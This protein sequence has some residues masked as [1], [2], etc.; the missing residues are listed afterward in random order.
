MGCQ[1]GGGFAEA[2]CGGH[3]RGGGFLVGNEE[4]WLD[5]AVMALGYGATA[6]S[7]GGP[8]SRDLLHVRPSRVPP[9]EIPSGLRRACW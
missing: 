8:S 6:S 9:A 5:G 3:G 7:R 1:E 2:S 4:G